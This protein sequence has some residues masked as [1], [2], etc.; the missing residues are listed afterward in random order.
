[1]I[2]RSVSAIHPG[3]ASRL[4]SNGEYLSTRWTFF[5]KLEAG[6]HRGCVKGAGQG[7]RLFGALGLAA[8]DILGYTRLSFALQGA[9]GC[10]LT[11][12]SITTT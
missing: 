5:L 11:T 1:M 10:A 2:T 7:S 12:I 4:L 6:F 8:I 9:L 3:R